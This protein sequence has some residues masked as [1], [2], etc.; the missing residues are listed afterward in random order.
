MATILSMSLMP[1]S[2]YRS[3]KWPYLVGFACTF[4]VL[5][6]MRLSLF[7]ASPL[8]SIRAELLGLEP[9]NIDGA[10]AIL[11]QLPDPIER[12]FLAEQWVAQNRGQTDISRATVICQQ[13]PTSQRK[14]CERHLSSA[15]LRR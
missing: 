3:K 11:D 10:V 2:F 1:R 8:Q 5:G 15:H 13:L 14:T 7:G 4:G 12:G 6:L 9:N